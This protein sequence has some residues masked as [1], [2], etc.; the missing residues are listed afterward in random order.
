MSKRPNRR[1]VRSSGPLKIPLPKYSTRE[2]LKHLR[3]LKRRNPI[4][5]AILSRVVVGV[6]QRTSP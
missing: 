5:Y 1:S 6:I 4:A 3:S 2:L